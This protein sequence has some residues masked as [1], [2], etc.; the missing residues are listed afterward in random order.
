VALG[1]VEVATLQP[2]ALVH[3]GGVMPVALDLTTTA[4]VVVVEQVPLVEQ[5]LGTTV[6]TVEQDSQLT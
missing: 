1:A 5:I 3:L 2:L 6:A 4:A